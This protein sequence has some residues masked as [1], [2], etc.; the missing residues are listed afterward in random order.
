MRRG[1]EERE[2]IDRLVIVIK[3][4]LKLKI[5]RNHYKTLWNRDLSILPSDG[6][7]FIPDPSVSLQ[8]SPHE[9]N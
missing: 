3:R 1:R 2:E 4:I 6:F 7:V 8:E 9:R 5:L